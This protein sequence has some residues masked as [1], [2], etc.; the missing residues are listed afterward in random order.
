LV[1]QGRFNG[2][3]SGPELNRGCPNWEGVRLGGQSTSDCIGGQ[4]GKGKGPRGR[5]S[6]RISFTKGDYWLLHF[7]AASPDYRVGWYWG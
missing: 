4:A 1:D 5:C 2:S 3:R 7:V 6:W